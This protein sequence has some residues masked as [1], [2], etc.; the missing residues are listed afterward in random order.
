[1]TARQTQ[2]S[3]SKSWTREDRWKAPND[4]NV[5]SNL[6]KTKKTRIVFW[7]KHFSYS[8]DWKRKSNCQFYV[9]STLQEFS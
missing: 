9:K 4:Y 6:A 7:K 1:M 8:R 2:D 3:T 5:Q